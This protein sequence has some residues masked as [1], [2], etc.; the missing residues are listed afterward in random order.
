MQLTEPPR[1]VSGVIRHSRG[2]AMELSR[3]WIDALGLLGVVAGL[4]LPAG[5]RAAAGDP[6]PRATLQGHADLAYAVAFSPDGKTLASGSWDLTARIWDVDSGKETATLRGHT[7]PIMSVAISADGKTLATGSIDQTVRVWDVAAGA[8]RR[9]LHG[10]ALAVYAVA[11]SPDGKTL[12]SGSY[13]KTVKLWDV[14][15]G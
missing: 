6:P 5:P 14:A 4:G 3:L 12:A 7:G 9:T 2:F 10:H 11:F 8:E 13:D 15:T 1:P